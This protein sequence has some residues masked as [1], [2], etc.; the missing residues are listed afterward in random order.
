MIIS[1]TQDQPSGRLE[2]IVADHHALRR[3]SDELLV[4]V[5]HARDLDPALRKTLVE[6]IGRLCE[7]LRL[8]FALEEDGGYMA[9]VLVRR[10]GLYLH[11]T[12]LREEHA[13]IL[14]AGSDLARLLLSEPPPSDARMRVIRLLE[15]IRAHELGEH[16]L[17]HDALVTDLGGGG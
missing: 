6:R 9:D 10:P 11:V 7:Q 17:L 16:A 14:A 15:S 2:N 1:M 12:R 4:L 3:E 13:V 5:E 8:H